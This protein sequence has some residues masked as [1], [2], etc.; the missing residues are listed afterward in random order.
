MAT[1]F[2]F[3]YNN[4]TVDFEDY[5]VRADFFRQGNLWTWGVNSQGQ[6]GDNTITHRSSP[7]Q[8]IT[9]GNNWSECASSQAIPFYLGAQQLYKAAIKT[10]GT[11]WVWGG[12]SNGGLGDNTTTHKS[13]PVQTV[14]G[15]TNW[16]KISL[17][18]GFSGAIKTDGTLW[19]WGIGNS[20]QHGDGIATNKSSPVQT[21]TF[22]TKWKQLSCGG[23]QVGAIKTDGTLW[24][25]GSNTSGRLGDNTTNNKSSPVQTV[26]VGTN[27]QQVSCGYIH[28]AAV[29]TDG[30]LW[31][32]GRNAYGQ[33][34]NN[35]TT[36]RSSP[37]QT[38]TA[39]TN[40]KQVSCGYQH[41]AAVKTDGTL[42]CWGMNTFGQL[43]N[44]STTG[45]LTGLSSPVQTI[46]GGNNWAFVS[47]G[48]A[49]TA[50]IKTD[51]T[52]WVWGRNVLGVLGDN[53]TTNRSSPVQTILR[54]STWRQ[55]S[56]GY[57]QIIALTYL[58]DTYSTAP[59]ATV[60]PTATASPATPTP[61]VTPI[62]STATPTPSVTPISSTPTPTPYVTPSAT[63]APG[64][65]QQFI[66]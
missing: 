51:G 22:D 18:Y 23:M 21:V 10:D 19:M 33:L 30:T 39:G 46:T 54:G 56:A 35:T 17:G 8:T 5:Y 57:R 36:D 29:K 26:T 65:T 58:D 9:F 61:S 53:T 55:V 43:G 48:Y 31:I 25:W 13:S 4:Q 60:A 11:L 66:P 1:K 14:T 34:G 15:G 7:V 40:W 32:W 64:P 6:L 24:M 50:A 42:W 44:N 63:G 62:S 3:N 16:K 59:S 28:T 12:N 41:T 37:V 49:I 2:R 20:G 38:V 27:W 45:A 47:T 52:L